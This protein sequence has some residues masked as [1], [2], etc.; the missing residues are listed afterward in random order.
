M[1][2]GEPGTCQ[3]QMEAP[4]LAGECLSPRPPSDSL[5][6]RDSWTQVSRETCETEMQ[7]TVEMREMEIQTDVTLPNRLDCLWHS[8]VIGQTSV[9]DMAQQRRASNT[10]VENDNGSDSSTTL[11]SR[12]C[13]MLFP[14]TLRTKM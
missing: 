2:E 13:L 7:A 5:I 3:Y 4:N 10:E 1:R 12:R 6:T 9:V 14:A 8:H 11:M